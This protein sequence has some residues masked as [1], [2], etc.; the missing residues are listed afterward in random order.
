MSPFYS[1]YDHLYRPLR[2]PFASPYGWWEYQ[3]TVMTDRTTTPQPAVP[4]MTPEQVRR[5]VRE[6]IAEVMPIDVPDTPPEDWG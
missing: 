2:N 3:R 1:Q 4:S 6:E 5:I